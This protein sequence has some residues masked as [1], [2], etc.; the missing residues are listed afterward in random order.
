[1]NGA[2]GK[3]RCEN[4]LPEFFLRCQKDFLGG[5]TFSRDTFFF[6][7]QG[8]IGRESQKCTKGSNAEGKAR[9]RKKF[10]RKDLGW[11]ALNCPTLTS[12][13][14]KGCTNSPPLTNTLDLGRGALN[15]PLTST[16]RKVHYCTNSPPLTNRLDLGRGALNSPHSDT[17]GSK[18]GAPVHPTVYHPQ[19]GAY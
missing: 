5:V 9:R 13:H 18:W 8:E 10:Y 6:L 7:L 4:L 19:K 3:Q 12:T 17:Q 2:K 14:R 1:M 15:R 16:H 11:G